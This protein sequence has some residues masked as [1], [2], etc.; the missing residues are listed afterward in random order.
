[1]APHQTYWDLIYLASGAYPKKFAFMMKEDLFR[2]LTLRFLLTQRNTFS[3]NWSNPTLRAIKTPIRV[4]ESTGSGVMMFS[5]GS[6]YS[7]D[8]KSITKFMKVP[9]LPAVYQGPTISAN[10]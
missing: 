5:T 10:Y 8:L 2:I 1:M 7:T 9:I 6:R 3:V 4:L